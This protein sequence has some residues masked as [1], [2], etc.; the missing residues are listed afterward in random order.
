MITGMKFSLLRFQ[1]TE[2]LF[3]VNMVLYVHRNHKV[4]SGQ[5]EGG[6]EVGGGKVGREIIYLSLHCHHQND[7]CIKRAILLFHNCEEQSQ[8]TMST[9]HNFWRERIA[10][11]DLNR[12]PSAY[13]PNT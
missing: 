3:Y 7:L 11:A 8:K 13:Q 9:D 5:G 2:K 10:E 6:M 1:L 12:V 4:Y